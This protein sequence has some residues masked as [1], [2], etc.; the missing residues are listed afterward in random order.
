VFDRQLQPLQQIGSAGD[1]PG[2]MSRPKGLAL[3][4]EDHLYIVDAQFEL[5]QIFDPHGVLLL[6]FGGEGSGPGEF[7]LPAGIHIDPS[8]RIWI[9]DTYNRRVQ[10]FQYLPGT[11]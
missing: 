6:S 2:Y 9:A 7:W 1:L 11:P 8:D 5:V 4:S 3:D 10:V